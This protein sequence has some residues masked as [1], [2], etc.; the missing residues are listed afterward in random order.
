MTGGTASD[1]GAFDRLRAGG[2]A[3]R[4][5][6]SVV[7]ITLTCLAAAIAVVPLIAVL[8][9]LRRQGA[10]ALSLDFFTKM[11]KPVGEPGGGM[12]NAIVGTLILIGMTSVVGLPLGIGAGLYLA[13]RLGNGLA[14]P[15]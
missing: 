6:V 2:L 1:H 15:V 7:M 3:R 10:G 14:A 11:P 5:G 4:H 12:A 8:I 9:Y 13:E